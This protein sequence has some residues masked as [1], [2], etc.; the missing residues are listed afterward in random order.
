MSSC[1][2]EIKVE[3]ERDRER[4]RER[5][6]NASLPTTRSLVYSQWQ[7]SLHITQYIKT[8]KNGIK[9]IQTPYLELKS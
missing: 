1:S 6:G 5:D 3:R 2:K 4:E 8:S 7:M 9:I